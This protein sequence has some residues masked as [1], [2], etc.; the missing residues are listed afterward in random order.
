MLLTCLYQIQS[1]IRLQHETWSHINALYSCDSAWC[2]RG[3]K[4]DTECA[5]LKCMRI[6]LYFS[7]SVLLFVLVSIILSIPCTII[8][9]TRQ[10]VQRL[11]WILTPDFCWISPSVHI[12][13]MQQRLQRTDT[14]L[15]V[16]YSCYVMF[17]VWDKKT[18][19]EWLTASVWPVLSVEL[20]VLAN[21]P[22]VAAVRL[23]LTVQ[24]TQDSTGALAVTKSCLK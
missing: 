22:L 8:L 13:K 6:H 15:D 5:G 18:M 2:E 1:V 16:T 4:H 3:V 9:S 19:A 21:Q 24:E 10:P 17:D 14:V 23:F 7:S 11:K 20:V 12:L